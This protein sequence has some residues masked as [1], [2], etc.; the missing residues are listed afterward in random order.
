MFPPLC[1]I[2]AVIVDR[3]FAEH[4][5]PSTDTVQVLRYAL[6]N[7]QYYYTVAVL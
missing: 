4:V 2:T 3:G 6:L 7:G 5:W 1:H